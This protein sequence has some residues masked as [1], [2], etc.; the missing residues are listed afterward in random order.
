VAGALEGK[1]ATLYSK[2]LRSGQEIEGLHIQ[3]PFAV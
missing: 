2:D 1:R 3:N